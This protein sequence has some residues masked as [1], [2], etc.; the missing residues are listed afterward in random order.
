MSITWNALAKILRVTFAWAV[1]NVNADQ[2][3]RV[4]YW[5]VKNKKL[6]KGAAKKPFLFHTRQRS[7]RSCRQTVNSERSTIRCPLGGK[8]QTIN[9]GVGRG[10]GKI[11]TNETKKV[12]RCPVRRV[13][14]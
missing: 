14:R 1:I 9:T 8:K 5:R 4:S 12:H 3:A 10:R 2:I 13:P 7:K 11:E 6:T